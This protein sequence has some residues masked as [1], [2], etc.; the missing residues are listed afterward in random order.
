LRDDDVFL[1]N[2]YR[3]DFPVRGFTSQFVIAHNR[4]REGDKNFVDDNGFLV[5]PAA[6]G[7][8]KKREYDVTYLGLNGDGHVGRWNISA[9]GYYAFGDETPSVFVDANTDISAFFGALEVSRDFDWIRLKGTA[10]YGS[11]DGDPYDDKATG[12]DA[13]FENPLIAGADTSF[14][15][16]QAFPLIG[17]GRIALSGQNGLLNSMRPSKGQ[18]QSNFTNPGIVLLGVGAD[19]DVTPKFRVSVN[20]NQLWFDRTEVLQAARN[21]G[22]IGKSI[23]QDV[24]LSVIYR[25][26]TSQNV[27]FRVAASALIPGDGFKDLYGSETPYSIL[28]NLILS[29]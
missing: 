20:I 3:Q 22:R 11:G 6:L 2:L 9:S 21:Q 14:W 28:A 16:R 18:G 7:I 15:I 4:N 5:R 29:Y 19:F 1:F 25:P 13:I 23:G 27:I 10:V 8:Q 26:F 24:S 17:G 12:F